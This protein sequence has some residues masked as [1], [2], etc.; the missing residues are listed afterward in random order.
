VTYKI[1]SGTG[2]MLKLLGG[3]VRRVP[4][5]THSEWGGKEAQKNAY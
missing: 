1:V 2:Q 4:F 5:E 3:K